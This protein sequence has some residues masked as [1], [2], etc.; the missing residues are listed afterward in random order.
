MAPPPHGAA[1]PQSGEQSWDFGD[2]FLLRGPEMS[3]AGLPAS[4]PGSALP[5]GSVDGR[6]GKAVS[7]SGNKSRRSASKASTWS[8]ALSSD[9]GCKEDQDRQGVRATPPRTLLLKRPHGHSSSNSKNQAL[10]GSPSCSTDE[11]TGAARSATRSGQ[12]IGTTEPPPCCLLSGRPPGKMCPQLSSN[13]P[14]G[15][16]QAQPTGVAPVASRPCPP[17]LGGW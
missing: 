4:S 3:E 16:A 10:T 12:P 6:A 17:L 7:A 11:E 1:L 8:S 2:G 13:K 9:L 5:V 14:L 15:T